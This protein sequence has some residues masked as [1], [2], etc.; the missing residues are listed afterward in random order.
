M[1]VLENTTL[2][3]GEKKSIRFFCEYLK[4]RHESKFASKVVMLYGEAGVGK[5]F[6]ARIL[7]KSIRLP[8]YYVG[9]EEFPGSTR[10]ESVEELEENADLSRDAL[11]YL[12][13]LNYHLAKDEIG[14]MTQ[15]SSRTF[16][17][18]LSRI[19]QSKARVG[20]L[21]TM[22]Y[23]HFDN[24][25]YDRIDIMIELG[26]PKDEAKQ[27]YLRKYR[28]YLTAEQ[29]QLIVSNSIGYNFR[30]LDEAVK[31]SYRTGHGKF[32][33]EKIREI[34]RDYRPTNFRHYEIVTD[35]K[36]KLS[37]VVGREGIKRKLK[38]V[39]ML[40]RNKDKLEDY[41]LKRANLLIFHGECGLGKTHMVKALAGEMGVPML[42]MNARAI[43]RRGPMEAF[44]RIRFFAE[45]FKDI[46]IFIDEADKLLGR[47]MVGDDG[48][49]QGMLNEMFDG[50]TE[51]KDT[52]VILS[53]NNLCTIGYPL[54]DRFTLVHF[55]YPTDRERIEFFKAKISKHRQLF[56][57][58]DYDWIAYRTRNLSFRTLEKIWNQVMCD[59]LKEN[60]QVTMSNFSDAMKTYQ[61]EG[62][63]LPG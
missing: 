58:I 6:L 31:L 60:R 36:L 4:G 24:Q 53:L 9:Q 25:I 12:D 39:I 10:F 52:L 1:R 56:Q 49:L 11:I 14:D 41:G 50:I 33:D 19:N 26:P 32:E 7:A 42:N 48:P 20:L 38:E 63:T 5:T 17:R 45:R 16:L 44:D 13:D 57:D 22:N 40:N 8:I 18:L 47:G 3:E 61:D 2:S 30:D 23:L 55:D 15:E 59:H 43:Y 21:G 46:I 51:L 35:T 34:L 54:Q 62:Y 27:R 37:D 28:G 29:M